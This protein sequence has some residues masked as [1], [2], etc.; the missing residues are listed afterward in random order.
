[1]V[2]VSSMYLL[3]ISFQI[4]FLRFFEDKKS[5]L[6][7]EFK[8]TVYIQIFLPNFQKWKSL[9]IYKLKNETLIMVPLFSFQTYEA[10]L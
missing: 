2:L 1:M 8:Y 9:Q 7:I 3:L 10:Q 6:S 4:D 5:T